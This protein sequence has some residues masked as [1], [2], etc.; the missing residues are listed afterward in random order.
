[1][2]F[3]FLGAPG[4]GKGTYAGPLSR[5]WGIPTISTGDLLRY[6]VKQGTALGVEAKGYMDQGALVPDQLVVRMLGERLNEADAQNGFILDGFPRTIPQ[7][8]ALEE[9]LNKG[10][11]KVTAVVNIDVSRDVIIRR[12]TGRRHCP[13][14][15][16]NFNVNTN[17]RPQKE[18]VCDHCGQTLAQRSDDTVETI[19]KRLEVYESQTAPL[20][21]YYRHAQMLVT[22]QATGDIAE[23]VQTI[24]SAVEMKTRGA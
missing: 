18:G 6:N 14:C 15:G 7:A 3:I 13:G 19:T 8:Q 4:A 17:L 11:K 1:M 16:A 2:R 10:G 20:I 12:L 9:L 5:E 21:D 22:V 23:I 24:R